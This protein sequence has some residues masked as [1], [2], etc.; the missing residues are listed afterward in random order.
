MARP[1]TNQQVADFRARMCEAAERLFAGRGTDAV[2]MRDLAKAL[3]VSVM[4]PYRYFRTKEEIL[5][6]V[7]AACLNRF[8]AALEAAYDSAEG[9][10]AKAAAV[11]EAYLDV[12]F[13]Q[14]RTYD[15]IFTL[16]QAEESLHPELALAG[17]RVRRT[18]TRYVRGLMD[19]GRITGDEQAVGQMFWAATHGCVLL[20]RSG[21]I[22]SGEARRTH[23]R[24]A[25][26]LARGLRP[27]APPD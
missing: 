8:A 20:E 13:E 10:A 17:S 2:T 19:E 22:A 9:A 11:G 26:T 7:R 6:M 14:P 5:A 4:T 23:R 18:M 3:G 25:A 27:T 1:L 24:M 16:D 15:A 12:A 21:M